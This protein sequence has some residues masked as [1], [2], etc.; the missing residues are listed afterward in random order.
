MYK[1]QVFSQPITIEILPLKGDV[2]GDAK[3]DMKDSVE[4][5]QA[6]AGLTDKTDEKFLNADFNGDNLLTMEDAVVLL[7]YLAKI[8]TTLE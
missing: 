1:R 3:V 6:V 7:Q 8:I 2:H 4:V 5:L